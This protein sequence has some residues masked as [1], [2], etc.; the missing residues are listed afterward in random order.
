MSEKPKVVKVTTVY[1]LLV[2]L[3][4]DTGR[5]EQVTAYIDVSKGKVIIPDHHWE[6]EL[7]W[8]ST[9]MGQLVIPL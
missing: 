4:Y 9:T 6:E 1:P 2:D 7:K 3:L 8:D 5:T